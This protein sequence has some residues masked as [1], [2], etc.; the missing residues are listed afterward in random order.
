MVG[1]LWGVGHS[2]LGQL[3]VGERWATVAL[4]RA[5]IVGDRR[6]EV[7][8][9]NVCGA[10]ALEQGGI[11]EATSFFTQAQ[12]EAMQDNDMATVGRCANNL[13]IIANIQGDYGR[14]VR[15]NPPPTPPYQP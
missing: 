14:A 4:A 7:R 12:E 3:E 5:Q 13:G 8:A 15:A 6:V 10:I 2:R 1:L 11:D 9:L